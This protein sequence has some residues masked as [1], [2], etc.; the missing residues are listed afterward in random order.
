MNPIILFGLVLIVSFG[1]LL[2]FLRPSRAEANIQRRMEGIDRGRAA[3]IE[4]N[5][6]LKEESRV[7]GLHLNNLLAQIPGSSALVDLIKQSGSNWGLAP[8]IFGSLAA[9]LVG[10]WLLSLW[11]P[12]AMMGI[13]GGVLIGLSP[14]TFLYFKRRARFARF[15]SLLPEAIDL[16]ARALRVGHSVSTVLDMVGQEV[17]EP[18]AGEFRTV[19]EEQTL[20]LPLREAMLNLVRRVPIQ[21]VRFLATAVVLQKETGGNLAEILDKTGVVMRDRIR[22]RGQLKVYTAQGRATGW[23]LCALPF[24]MFGLISLVNPSYEKTLFTDPL[25]VHMIYAGIIMMVLGVLIIRRIIDV[26]I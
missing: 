4:A 8:L 25:G 14:C 20:G 3:S 9:A 7:T 26:R 11:L 22:L 12:T 15:S 6:I 13:V 16:M 1:V 5:T 2:Y 18:V 23:V 24:L 17:P 21:D 19:Y 10:G